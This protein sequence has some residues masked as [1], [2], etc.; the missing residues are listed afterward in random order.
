MSCNAARTIWYLQEPIFMED[1][2]NSNRAIDEDTSITDA[3]TS[4]DEAA[5]DNITT[6]NSRETLVA[7][8]VESDKD[9]NPE[10]TLNDVTTED[11]S[12]PPEPGLGS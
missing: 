2:S 3:E 11:D 4:L 9:S 6:Q 12:A 1:N 8:Q 5:P 10:D 7:N